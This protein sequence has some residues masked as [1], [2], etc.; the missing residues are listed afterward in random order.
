MKNAAQIK[1]IKTI[2]ELRFMKPDGWQDAVKELK[3]KLWDLDD[4]YHDLV[5]H[6]TDERGRHGR[7]PDKSPSRDNYGEGSH[8]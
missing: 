8:P 1:I 6:G 7:T 5:S 3:I 4:P 2:A